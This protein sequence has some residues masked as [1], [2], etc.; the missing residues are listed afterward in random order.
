MNEEQI[1][2]EI[3]SIETAMACDDSV[4]EGSLTYSDAKE[5]LLKL[6]KMLLKILEAKALNN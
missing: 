4:A 2:E 5:R 3:N 6:K 1:R